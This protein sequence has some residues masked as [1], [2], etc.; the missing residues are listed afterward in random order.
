M[1]DFSTNLLD[2]NVAWKVR[3]TSELQRTR[4]EKSANR[5]ARFFVFLEVQ[6]FLFE[7]LEH[8]GKK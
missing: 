6:R 8:Y 2:K 5:T 3:E 1:M 7:T 4:S